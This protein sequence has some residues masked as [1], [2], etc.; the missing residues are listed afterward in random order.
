MFIYGRD[1][2]VADNDIALEA[3]EVGQVVDSWFGMWVGN[4]DS[5]MVGYSEIFNSLVD[6]I[7]AGVSSNML[8]EKAMLGRIFIQTVRMKMSE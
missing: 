3:L 5:W 2:N 6:N 8:I 1:L 4:I 7:V